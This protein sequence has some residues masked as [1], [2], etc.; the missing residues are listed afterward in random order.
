MDILDSGLL[1]T[2]RIVLH[3]DS[4]V[5]SCVRIILFAETK[6][7]HDPMFV[8]KISFYMNKQGLKIK[9]KTLAEKR[10]LWYNYK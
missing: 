8:L 6:A 4:F 5:S 2:C 1:V 7:T 3:V 9:Y 10:T